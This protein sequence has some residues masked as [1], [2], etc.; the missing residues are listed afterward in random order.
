MIDSESKLE[1]E[2]SLFIWQMLNF[3]VEPKGTISQVKDRPKSATS[4]QEAKQTFQP[5]ALL[6]VLYYLQKDLL[7][8]SYKT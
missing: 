7:L 4:Y 8:S 3:S 2:Q 1:K 6:L 5:S